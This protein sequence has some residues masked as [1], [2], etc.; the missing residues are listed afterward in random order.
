[1]M[2][3]RTLQASLF[4]E[5]STANYI[6]NDFLLLCNIV[7][8]KCEVCVYLL[9]Y[10]MAQ[11]KVCLRSDRSL[12]QRK[13][14]IH[15]AEMA[16]SL[17]HENILRLYGVVL[18]GLYTDSVALVCIFMLFSFLLFIF[19]QPNNLKQSRKEINNY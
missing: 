12:S 4:I 7:T 17:S 19:C 16:A 6:D 11:V 13:N 9:F 10:L 14:F 15:E 8:A 1:M 18:P 5:S 3:W 2:V